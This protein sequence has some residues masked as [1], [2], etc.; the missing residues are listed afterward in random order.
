MLAEP[1]SFAVRRAPVLPAKMQTPMAVE[2]RGLPP[3]RQLAL[4]YRDRGV[5]KAIGLFRSGASG[6]GTLPPFVLQVDGSYLMR[7]PVGTQRYLHLKVRR[8]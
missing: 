2:V 5:W 1:P 6:R 8:G 7:I 3:H 4:Y